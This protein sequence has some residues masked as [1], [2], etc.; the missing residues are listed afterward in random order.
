MLMN[1]ASTTPAQPL[2]LGDDRYRIVLNPS[3][4]GYSSCQGWCTLTRDGADP[5]L[6][7][8]GFFIYLRDLDSGAV[9]SPTPRPLGQNATHHGFAADAQ[10]A[11]FHQCNHDITATLEV[12]LCPGASAELRRLRL[13]NTGTAPRR[14]DVTGYLEPVI[15]PTAADACHPAFAKL[16]VQTAFEPER[17]VLL[18]NRRARGHN[19]VF[20]WLVHG[21]SGPG[22]LQYETDRK[23]FIGRGR[24]LADPAALGNSGQWAVVSG[25][26]TE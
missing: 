11:T 19:E 20:P 12:S 10:R 26:R 14:L 6:D 1:S 15:F 21:L 23:H 13:Q 9:W 3:G 18:V 25:Q 7:A 4:T 5:L 24:S 17:Q 16:F 8:L 22:E 2:V